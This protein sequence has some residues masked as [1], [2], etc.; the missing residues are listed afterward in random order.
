MKQRPI[1]IEHRFTHNYRAPRHFQGPYYIPTDYTIRFWIETDPA[2]GGI[3]DTDIAKLEVD[4]ALS[5]VFTD[6]GLATPE[7]WALDLLHLLPSA[8]SV[9]ICYDDGQGVAVHRDWP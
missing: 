7:K 2:F 8:N 9:E 3:K 5:K 1:V 6:P 4:Q